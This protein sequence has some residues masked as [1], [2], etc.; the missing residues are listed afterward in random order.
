MWVGTLEGKDQYDEQGY[1]GKIRLEKYKR[2]GAGRIS[3][4][5][6]WILV[7]DK[8]I[9]SYWHG[10]S[11]YIVSMAIGLKDRQTT[12]TKKNMKNRSVYFSKLEILNS[13]LPHLNF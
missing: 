7:V 1:W 4:I 5:N 11:I 9:F 13:N 2:R 8:K 12:T 10:I 6:W 3:D